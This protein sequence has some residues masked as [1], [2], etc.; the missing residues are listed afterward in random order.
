MTEPI[1]QPGATVYGLY[2]N[3]FDSGVLWK[4]YAR[5]EDARRE[6]IRLMRDWNDPGGPDVRP[7]RLLGP[8]TLYG[9]VVLPLPVE[10]TIEQVRDELVKARRSQW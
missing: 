5:E 3:R 7:L 10:E 4:T 6:C 1:A 9:E 8:E 2:S